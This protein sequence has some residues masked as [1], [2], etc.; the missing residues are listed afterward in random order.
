M[1]SAEIVFYILFKKWA[2]V[3]YEVQNLEAKPRAF[4][5]NKRL[6]ANFLIDFRNIPRK[7]CPMEIKPLLFCAKS[8]LADKKNK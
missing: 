4:T 5:P 2:V 1:T 7:T 3:F 8:E 6:A